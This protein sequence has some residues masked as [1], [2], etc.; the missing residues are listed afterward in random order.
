MIGVYVFEFLE[1]ECG[2]IVSCCNFVFLV[3]IFEELVM[4]SVNGV[5]VCYLIKYVFV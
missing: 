1:S 2:L 5:F 4:G 3:D